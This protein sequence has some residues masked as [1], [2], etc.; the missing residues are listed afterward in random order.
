MRLRRENPS[1]INYGGIP[2]GIAV[3][4]FHHSERY[5]AKMQEI[6]ALRRAKKKI[7]IAKYVQ[8]LY[9][10]INLVSE[11]WQSYCVSIR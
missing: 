6:G 10:L 4:R 8:E 3:N 11:R 1:L 2:M 7:P 9:T 5:R